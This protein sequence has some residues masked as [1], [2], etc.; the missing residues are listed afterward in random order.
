MQK[1]IVFFRV[2]LETKHIKGDN[3][4]VHMDIPYN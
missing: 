2:E 1:C 3:V 4:N